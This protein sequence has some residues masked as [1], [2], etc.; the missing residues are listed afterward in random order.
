MW[1]YPRVRHSVLPQ[2]PRIDLVGLRSTFLALPGHRRFGRSATWTTAPGRLAFL[3]DEPPPHSAVHYLLHWTVELVPASGG[4][5]PGWPG[6][7]RR[8]GPHPT[9][10]PPSRT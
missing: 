8:G 9:C 10:Y 3:S 1:W 2:H 4:N 6:S 5:S 7:T